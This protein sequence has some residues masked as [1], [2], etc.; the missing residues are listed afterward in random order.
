MKFLLGSV[1]AGFLTL[2]SAQSFA[3]SSVS[4]PINQPIYFTAENAYFDGS[5]IFAGQIPEGGKNG[6]I[7]LLTAPFEFSSGPHVKVIEGKGDELT[8]RLE[9]TPSC[10]NGM[11]CKFVAMKG[12]FKLSDRAKVVLLHNIQ[13]AQPVGA[14]LVHIDEVQITD[15]YLLGDYFPATL[16]GL[17]D[18]VSAH[19]WL[20]INKLEKPYLVGVN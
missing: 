6:T 12:M 9:L 13:K 20:T 19:F 18:W 15:F 16:E 10:P 17:A 4:V 3:A 7:Q 5:L 14:P 11:T 8:V 2:T 1:L